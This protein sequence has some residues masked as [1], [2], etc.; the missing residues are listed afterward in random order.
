MAWKRR[1]SLGSMSLATAV[2]ITADCTD[3]CESKAEVVETGWKTSCFAREETVCLRRP[4]A[5]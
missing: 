1:S 5:R 2:A 4:A 3:P